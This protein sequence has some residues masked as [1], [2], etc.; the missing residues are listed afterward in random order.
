MTTVVDI[1]HRII[2]INSHTRRKYNMETTFQPSL[3]AFRSK[4]ALIEAMELS[5]I[6]FVFWGLL[7]LVPS[8]TPETLVNLII[9]LMIIEGFL[10]GS[11]VIYNIYIRIARAGGRTVD[12]VIWVLAS[13]LTGSYTFWAWTVLDLNR[14]LMSKLLYRGEAPVEYAWSWRSKLMRKMWEQMEQAKS[15]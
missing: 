7:A 6:G 11:W 4:L 15:N 9:F 5:V 14:W 2:K 13:L 10:L 3:P 12:I 1:F 8:D